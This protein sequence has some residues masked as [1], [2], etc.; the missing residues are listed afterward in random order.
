MLAMLAN[1]SH[2]TRVG[3][4]LG[5]ENKSNQITFLPLVICMPIQLSAEAVLSTSVDT[6]PV[7]KCKR[8]GTR[9]ISVLKC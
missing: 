7:M 8:E 6:A 1:Y 4:A 9:L 2:L 5:D 3:R